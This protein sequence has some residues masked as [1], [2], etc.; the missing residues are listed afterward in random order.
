MAN[1]FARG[2][3]TAKRIRHWGKSWVD[4][5]KII[6]GLQGKNK[7]VF[8]WLDDE[9]VCLAVRRHIAEV[10][11]KLTSLNLAKAVNSYLLKD[12]ILDDGSLEMALSDAISESESAATTLELSKSKKRRIRA[13][14]AR[15][16]LRK[17]GF[18]WKDIHKGVYIDGHEREDVVRYR[19][20]VFIPCF[21][22]ILPS[23]REWDE[24]G[25]QLIKE[26]PSGEKEKILVTH[27]ESTFNANDGK[28]RMWIQ[29]DA[30]PLR[31]KSKGRGIMVSEF[32]TP[33]GRL[34]L[35]DNCKDSI[36][37]NGQQRIQATEYLEY[38]QDNYWTGE[39]MVRHTVD[40]A[41]PIFEKRYP[42]CQAVFIFDNAS[43][44]AAF[45]QDA[46][47]AKNM[48][49]GPGGKQPKMRAGFIHSKQCSQSM[50]NEAGLP[51]GI[52]QVLIERGLWKPTMKLDCKPQCPIPLV[53]NC[54]ARRCISQEKDFVDQRGM[55]Q[56]EIEARGHLVLFYPKFHCELNFI[57][58]F[59]AAAK[60]Y[61]R[62]NCE[63]SLPGLRETIPAALNSVEEVTIW[64]FYQK[65]QR[66]LAAYRDGCTY[67][68]PDFCQRV[69]KS[70]RR[71]REEEY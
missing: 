21:D 12:G 9:G 39:K 70:H 57:E 35:P 67:G 41:I 20:E 18:N 28:R 58:F 47:V 51:K 19:N 33:R 59:W 11:D 66:T 43:N 49:L 52:K 24:T 32:M 30:Q 5:R 48:N 46:L 44:H 2:S 7:R 56:E 64:R 53:S 40:I 15:N 13:R 42:D 50:V 37:I 25:N 26:L 16:W 55:L 29:G 71:V 69:Y 34:C 17:L 63:Y 61:T 1:G 45:A 23:L 10:G 36:T 54:C 65:T 14:T 22:R 68:S 6:V 31:Q 38:G 62:E 60:R 27:D 4:D 3:T 8:T